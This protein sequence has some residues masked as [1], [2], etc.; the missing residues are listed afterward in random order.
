MTPDAPEPYQEPH[1]GD[2]VLRRLEIPRPFHGL[3]FGEGWKDLFVEAMMGLKKLGWRGELNEARSK[4][5]YLKVRVTPSPTE[6][7]RVVLGKMQVRSSTICET[8]G[9]KMER[10]PGTLTATCAVKHQPESR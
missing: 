5:G 8:C 3:Q 2:E 6:Q 10:T 4:F 1:W 7:Q 9:A